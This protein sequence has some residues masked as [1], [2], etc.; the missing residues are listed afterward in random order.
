MNDW[1]RQEWV[2]L[3]LDECE[4]WAVIGLADPR[5]TAYSI[6]SLLQER[7]KQ[8]VPIHPAA[9]SPEGLEVLGERGYAAQWFQCTRTI[10]QSFC[11]TQPS[12][13]G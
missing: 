5:R 11:R 10:G 8:I 1:Q 9:A 7:G 6:A 3:M 13:S 12:S 4:T 2:D